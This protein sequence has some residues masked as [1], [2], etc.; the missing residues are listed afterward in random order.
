MSVVIIGGNIN[1]MRATP[2]GCSKN[3]FPQLYVVF[4]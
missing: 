4:T 1:T 3:T 2:G